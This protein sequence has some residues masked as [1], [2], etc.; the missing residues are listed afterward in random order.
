MSAEARDV[1]A[2]SSDYDLVAEF[3]AAF[4][5][6]T[7]S[8]RLIRPEDADPSGVRYALVHAPAENAFAP[9]SGL[10]MVCSWGAGVDKLIGHRGLG[11]DIVLN[12]MVDSGQAEMMAAF[13]AHYVT[14]W[15]RGMFRYPA[16]QKSETWEIVNWT[17]NAEV[18]VGLLGFGHMGAAI[19]RGLRALGYPVAAW[20][21][22]TRVEEGIEVATGTNGMR[23]LLEGSTVLINSLPLTP[24]TAGL[25]D[26]DIFAAMRPDA[27]FVHLGRGSQVVEDDLIAALDAGRPGGAALDVF[28]TEPLPWGHPLWRHPKVMVTP[29]AAS[30]PSP[31][32][33]A[34]A[35]AL[36]IASHEAGERPPGYVDRAKGY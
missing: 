29:H 31:A 27:L 26:A 8:L 1:V 10:E 32:G 17:P 5:A 2:L 25:F 36:A 6:Q 16:Q 9:Y 7:G 20:A 24:A 3:G 34:R 28:A 18:Q 35:V 19:G 4:A 30:A 21:A 12:R 23:I 22:R 13:A 14:G 11:R 33:V 15:H